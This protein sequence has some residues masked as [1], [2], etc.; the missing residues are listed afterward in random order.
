[1]RPTRKPSV[2][3]ANLIRPPC[4]PTGQICPNACAQAHHD[5]IVRNHVA[6]H[7]E[8]SGWRL[9]GRELVSPTGVRISQQRMHGMIWRAENADL[10]DSLRK[11]NAARKVRQQM[12]KVVVV[13]LSDYRDR[14]LG[15]IAG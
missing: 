6:L 9:A 12:V 11:R 2:D 10:R 5:H 1:M 8:W 13:N 14:H 3:P 4:W 15:R 7:G